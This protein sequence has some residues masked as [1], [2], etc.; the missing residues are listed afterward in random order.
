MKYLLDVNVLVAWGWSDH[1]EHER[2]ARWL[3]LARKQKSTSLLTSAIP[4]LG[5]VRVSVQRTGGSVTVREAS[6]T[7]GG[8]L[9]S[10]GAT[11]RF[12]VDDR[13]ANDFPDWC[14]HASRTTDAH[15]C[16]L[17]EAHGAKLATLDTGIPGAFLL[18]VL[19]AKR[20]R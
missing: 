18:P 12:L 10:L 6:E 13:A 2:T 17:A 8:M 11:H 16:R 5:F 14:H 7:L 3:A 20:S 9:R 19:A 15:L 1:V 4:E